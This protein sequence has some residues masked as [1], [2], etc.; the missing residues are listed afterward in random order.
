MTGIELAHLHQW[1]ELQQWI[2]W[3][4]A[5]LLLWAAWS[6]ATSFRIPNSLTLALLL[7]YIADYFSRAEPP[8]LMPALGTA[9]I[10]L[11]VGLALFAAGLMGGGDVKLLAAATLWVGPQEAM[12]FAILTSVFGGLLGL[13]L[14]TPLAKR[15]PLP[16]GMS[17][18]DVT[19]AWRRPMPYGV[20]IALGGLIAGPALF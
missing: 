12:D 9:L 1:P 17:E 5:L 19:R 14:L 16:A 18:A 20:A 4:W 13:V 3:A 6:D 8:D 15:M 11:L 7:L 10:V 2:V